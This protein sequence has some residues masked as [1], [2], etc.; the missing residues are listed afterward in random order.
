M[1]IS[2]TDTTGLMQVS[3]VG[4]GATQFPFPTVIQQQT[5][6]QNCR[7]KK[8]DRFTRTRTLR[9]VLGS[10]MGAEKACQKQH[11]Q[12]GIAHALILTVFSAYICIIYNSKLIIHKV[13]TLLGTFLLS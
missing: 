10:R 2:F 6:K 3:T 13:K 11:I 1:N 8:H 9:S 7:L 4:P 12:I 5:S